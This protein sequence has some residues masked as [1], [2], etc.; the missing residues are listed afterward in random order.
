VLRTTVRAISTTKLWNGHGGRLDRSA[1]PL[2]LGEEHRTRGWLITAVNHLL[3][4]LAP[5]HTWQALTRRLFRSRAVTIAFE[6][7]ILRVLANMSI[8]R[9][10][11]VIPLLTDRANVSYFCT[12]GITW[13]LNAPSHATSGWPIW[14]YESLVENHEHP[15]RNLP[16]NRS[17]P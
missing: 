5:L 9:N 14:V 10:S 17:T 12:G 1:L 16:T 7:V 6:V 8:C 4:S 3:A 15:M 13:G 2:L 11:T